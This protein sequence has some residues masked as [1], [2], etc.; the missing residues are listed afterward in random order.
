MTKVFFSLFVLTAIAAPLSAQQRSWGEFPMV[1]T[2]SFARQASGSN[3]IKDVPEYAKALKVYERLCEARG[4]F[5]YPVPEFYITR[6]RTVAEIEYG[7]IPTI[8]LSD[9]A[10]YVCESFGA[11]SE[12]ALAFLL[13]HE[14]THYYEKHAWRG[15]FA[16]E[17]RELD[18]SQQLDELYKDMLNESGKNARFRDKLM[19]FDTL[20]HQFEDA[21]MEAQSDYLGGFLAYSAGYGRFEQGDELIRRLYKAFKLDPAIPGY[22]T[23]AEREKMSQRSAQKLRDFVDVF[24][25]ANWL[26]A[27]GLYEEAYRYYRLILSEYQ[28]RE[29]YNNVGATAMLQALKLFSAE[30][31][32]F[33]YPVQLDLE[34]ASS[35]GE[36]QIAQRQRLL[37]Q[38]VLHFDA[39]IS[40]DGNYAPAYLNKACA[41]ALLNDPVRAAFYADV[42]ARRAAVGKFASNVP[43]I[44]ILLGILEANTKTEEGKQKAK[45]KFELAMTTDVSGLAA[46]NLAILTGQPLPGPASGDTGF[47]EDESIDGQSLFNV[48]FPT[49]DKSM[50]IDEVLNFEQNTKQGEHSRLYVSYKNR[51]MS[52]LFHATNP[53]YPGETARGIKVGNSRQEVLKQYGPPLQV[54]YT[55]T[56]QLLR[57]SEV[58]FQMQGELVERWLLYTV[59]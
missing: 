40:L 54:I 39:A 12:A 15:N 16:F 45:A 44:E 28:S 23:Q 20:I 41:L 8:Y 7:T 6:K 48:L 52:A 4:D 32:K 47:F 59:K 27:V 42:E 51:K 49:I 57:Y 5:R 38:A 19:R 36:E 17:H 22:V 13:G 58:I 30:E 46:H 33:R 9:T 14:L 11:Q 3:K 34:M 25:M 2:K 29:I 35:R 10:F 18:I 1:P 37:Q 21:S 24:E 43:Y 56:G 50:M 53:N 55:P 26:T 31:L